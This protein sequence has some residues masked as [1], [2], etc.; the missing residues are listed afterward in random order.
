MGKKKINRYK[1]QLEM[2]TS[3][4]KDDQV[5]K[6]LSKRVKEFYDQL[7]PH[8][9]IQFREYLIQRSK[10]EEKKK[11]SSIMETARVDDELPVI[12]VKRFSDL[13]N[14]IKKARKKQKKKNRDK[15]ILKTK[16][17]VLRLI[18]PESHDYVM[19]G[20][21]SYR[22][23]LRKLAMDEK[24]NAGIRISSEMEDFREK[25]FKDKK[26]NKSIMKSFWD[27]HGC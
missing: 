16:D 5:I 6:S 23:T 3:G 20:D 1:K 10:W 24:K 15:H 9:Q 26:V 4:R 27:K 13:P 12:R 14:A 19:L 22:K 21:K 8:R 11:L 7:P 18:N 2:L 17:G 25:L